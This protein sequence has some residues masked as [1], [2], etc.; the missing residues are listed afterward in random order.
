MDEYIAKKASCIFAFD[1]AY[2]AGEKLVSMITDVI[3]ILRPGG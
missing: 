3:G 1:T 2:F